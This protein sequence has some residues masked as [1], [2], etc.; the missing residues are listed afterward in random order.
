MSRKKVNKHID[1]IRSE[2]VERISTTS[3]HTQIC[4]AYEI[5]TGNTVSFASDENEDIKIVIMGNS[6]VNK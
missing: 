1:E 6:I 2:V 4:R 3:N 5:I